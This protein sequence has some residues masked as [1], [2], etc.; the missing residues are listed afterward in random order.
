MATNLAQKR[1]HAQKRMARFRGISWQ[2]TFDEWNRWWL[3]HGV[4]RATWPVSHSQDSLCMARFGDEGPYNINNVYLT[5]RRENSRAAFTINNRNASKKIAVITP[6]GRFDSMRAA[7]H[8][9]DLPY[10]TL[11]YRIHSANYPEFYR[12]E[13]NEIKTSST[14]RPTS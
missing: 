1:Y 10:C 9:N 14:S 4:D 3:S 6:A 11:R 5:T 2:F 7:S 13:N 12:E 8:A